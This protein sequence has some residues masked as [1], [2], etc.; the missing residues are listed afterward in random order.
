MIRVRHFWTGI[1]LRGW[2]SN[3][4]ISYRTYPAS[5]KSIKGPISYIKNVMWQTPTKAGF[6]LMK[7]GLGNQLN[8][9]KPAVFTNRRLHVL[10][11]EASKK[12]KESQEKGRLCF[13]NPF[14]FS[15]FTSIFMHAQFSSHL[16]WMP[17]ECPPFHRV[18]SSYCPS[19]AVRKKLWN[20]KMKSATGKP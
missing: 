9:W 14:C 12:V 20:C 3:Q 2:K 7:K 8:L 10:L 17:A 15:L 18:P 1:F 13:Q 5:F 6:F 19:S 4:R 16:L 11:K